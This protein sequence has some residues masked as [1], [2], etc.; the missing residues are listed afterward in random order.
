MV[1][2]FYESD[3]KEAKDVK[4]LLISEGWSF[5][6]SCCLSNILSTV[7][8]TLAGCLLESFSLFD[9]FK[10]VS[11]VLILSMITVFPLISAPGA[12]QILK[13]WGAALIRGRR[14]FQ[15]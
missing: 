4:W 7:S 5:M 3:A 12:Y 6:L 2:L 9:S 11:G 8:Q 10:F 15:T 14:L 13:L 1:H